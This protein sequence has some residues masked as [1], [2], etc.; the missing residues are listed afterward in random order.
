MQRFLTAHHVNKREPASAGRRENIRREV[1]GDERLGEPKAS[2]ENGRGSLLRDESVDKIKETTQIAAI[3]GTNSKE[4]GGDVSGHPHSVLNVQ[5]LKPYSV[6]NYLL[7][8]GH[9]GRRTPSTL[10]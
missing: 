4:R 5:G 1:L 6:S 10:V 3:V 2:R 8:D 7:R 9:L